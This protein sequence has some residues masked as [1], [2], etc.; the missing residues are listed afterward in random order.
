MKLLIILSFR[1]IKK[2][3]GRFIS[4]ILIVALGIGFF[5]G[6]RESAPDILMTLDNFYDQTNL[7]DYKIIS[8]KGLTNE[9]VESLQKLTQVKKVIPSYS[10]DALVSGEAIR[11]HSLTTE[12]NQV[13]LVSGRMIKNNKECLA[14]ATYFNLGDKIHLSE[15]SLDGIL[16]IVDYEVVGLV[17]S[18]L[19]LSVERGISTIGNGKLESFIFINYDNFQ[20]EFI[21]EVYLLGKNSQE[22]NSYDNS[23]EE[24]LKKLESEI[25]ELKPIQ[26]TKRYEEILEEATAEIQKIEDE[27]Q[28]ERNKALD[29]LNQASD[30]LKQARHKLDNGWQEY[31]ESKQLLLTNEQKGKQELEQAENELNQGKL[32]YQNTLNKYNLQEDSI[33]DLLEDTK[34]QIE[35][36][37]VTLSQ[38]ETTDPNYVVYQEQL[39]SLK[40]LEILYNNLLNTK[41]TLE[42]SE[43]TL[44]EEQNKYNEEITNGYLQLEQAKK[45]LE[46]GEIEYQS[47]LTEYNEGVKQLEEKVKEAETKIQE[48]KDSLK[49]IEKPEWYLL[50]RTNNN[51]YISIY[52]DA[53][54]IEAIAKVFPIF[55]IIV[56]ALMCFNTLTR[57]IE[58]ERGEIGTL[59]SLGYGRGLITT[60]YI[61]FVLLA[62]FIGI[63]AGLI[64]GYTIIPKVV[65][66]IYHSTYVLPDLEVSIKIIPFIILVFFSLLIMLLITIISCQKELRDTPANIIRPKSPK[67]GKKVLL[68]NITFFWKRLS[69]TSKVTV[70]NMFR[71]KKRIIMTVLGIAG[72]TALLLA[73][74]GLRDSINELIDLQY[75]NLIHYDALFVMQNNYQELSQELQKDLNLSGVVEYLPVYQETFIFEAKD[76]SHNAYLMAFA[77]DE[78]ISKYL[79]L[80]SKKN[81]DFSFPDDGVIITEKMSDLL[82]IQIGDL[83][84]IR[85]SKNELYIVKVSDIVENYT[86]HY[87]YMNKDVYKKIFDQ[88]IVYNTVMANLKEDIDNDELA[89]KWINDNKVTT[90]NFTSDNYQIFIN[91]VASLNKIVYLIIIASCLLAFV[92]L[93]NLTTINITERVR[94][95]STLKVLGFYDK[96]VSNYIYR[97]TIMLT[98]FGIIFGL[99]GGIFLHSY[100]MDIAETDNILF[101][102]YINWYSYVLSFII[103][104]IFGIIVQLFTHFK[105][106]KINMIEALKSIE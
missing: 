71:Y 64:G 4:I 89:R 51:G 52:E 25:L 90:I 34:K 1:K 58:E 66:Q 49:E 23:Y 74:F 76:I 54:K 15:V 56:V 101:C 85:N 61:V 50:D 19:Y 65:Y 47:G 103:I 29:E 94:E 22:E 92:V 87:I 41:N 40:Q 21:T 18:S 24:S 75:K 46:N 67:K 30:N 26:E 12:I 79:T 93:Y 36:L 10:V 2:S 44:Q 57:M 31:D 82:K 6:L 13:S 16:E 102:H 72:S 83:I 62:A 7:M 32:S 73:G 14:D 98:L 53:M 11:V 8:T 100:V 45:E 91:M 48:A 77:N 78:E 9:D 99:F 33:P 105:L 96:E 69:F 38:I 55:F 17:N 68:E 106:K 59:A 5:A 60:G 27:F 104:I 43:K 3:L 80:N 95:I 42:T 81:A 37:E 97:E 35:T 20:S 84:K 28:I 88:D 39:T 86:M 70:R 63:T